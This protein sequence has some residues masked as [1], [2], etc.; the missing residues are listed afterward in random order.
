MINN[1]SEYY[2]NLYNTMVIDPAK[3]GFVTP[4]VN[5]IVKNTGIYQNI[6]Y[7]V[8]I[9]MPYWFV[10][11][12]HLQECNLLFDR[13][14]HNGD[15]LTH[16]TTHVPMGYPKFAP[17]GL[18]KA[19]TF[20]ESAIDALKLSKVDKITDWSMSNMLKTLEGY[21]GFGYL[22]HDINTPYLWSFTNQYTKGKYISDGHF[23]SNAVSKQLG[24]ACII[25]RLAEK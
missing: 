21:N 15:P 25:K 17:T 8:N 18:N 22:H 2:L 5:R 23:D 10:A 3:M 6:A 19:Y 14:L 12:I 4:I 20:E 9:S 11:V 13:H 24:I 16:R 1:T 7:K